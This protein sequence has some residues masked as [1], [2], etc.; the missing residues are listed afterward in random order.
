VYYK[1]ES[2]KPRVVYSDSVEEALCFGWIDSTMRPLD[3]ER[4]MQLFT[5]RKPKSE[6][7]KLNKQRVEKLIAD[8]MMTAAGMEKIEISKNNGHWEK[9]DQVESLLP[10]DDLSKQLNKNKKAFAFFNSLRITNKKYILHWLNTAKRSETRVMRIE[11]IMEALKKGTMPER[12][13]PAPK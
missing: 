7:S 8:G 11:E 3:K 1:K 13:L 10:P 4:Y 2:G 5:P 6:W 9:N 12:F